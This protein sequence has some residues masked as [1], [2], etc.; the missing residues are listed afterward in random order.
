MPG[1]RPAQWPYPGEVDALGD[2]GIDGGWFMGGS[3]TG[4]AGLRK[5]GCWEG[6]MA[7]GYR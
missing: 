1:L 7:R 2:G 4:S 3:R 6:H 5:M